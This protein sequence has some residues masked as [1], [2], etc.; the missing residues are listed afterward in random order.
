MS[1]S[2][3][4]IP[5]Q[6]EHDALKII[7][8]RKLKGIKF[9]AYGNIQMDQLKKFD[10]G[11]T[12]VPKY[13]T[14]KEWGKEENQQKL[15]QTWNMEKYHQLEY[16]GF[17][18]LGE[19]NIDE[20]HR[21]MKIINETLT[22]L[23]LV[24]PGHLNWE[25]EGLGRDVVPFGIIDDVQFKEAQ[26]IIK[27]IP[28]YNEDDREVLYRSLSWYSKGVS[29]AEPFIKFLCLMVAIESLAMYIE[30]GKGLED[31]PFLRIRFDKKTKQEKDKDFEKCVE[32]LL[33]EQLIVQ[34]S[35]DFFEKGYSQCL[36]GI[37]T[38]VKNH[39][40]NLFSN[41]YELIQPLFDNVGKTK[42]F[43]QIRHDVAHGSFNSLNEL[44]KENIRR[45]VWKLAKLARMYILLVLT[46][47]DPTRNSN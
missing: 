7:I 37:Q 12:L 24:G 3:S 31:S 28:N 30:K 15:S 42:S 40:T 21:G 29:W 8:Q 25:M 34:N 22:S 45:N 33:K 4:N 36:K 13:V 26:R 44:D 23:S 5:S 32:N 39:L 18:P 43:Y 1:K 41:N 35:K 2:N 14:S 46:K 27:N 38:T 6:F 16:E 47:T 9:I 11:L 17:F 10:N 19:I 20:V